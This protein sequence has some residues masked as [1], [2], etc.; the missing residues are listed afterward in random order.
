MDEVAEAL[1]TLTPNWTCPHCKSVNLAIR[2]KCRS[3]GYDSNCGEFPWYNPL[4]P[5]DELPQN[6]RDR[7]NE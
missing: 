7:N 1:W 5:Y 6:H 2:E 4:P 3:C